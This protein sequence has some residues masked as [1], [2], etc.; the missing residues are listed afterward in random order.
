MPIVNDSL[1]SDY[2]AGAK[3]P[4]PPARSRGRSRG[5]ASVNLNAPPLE[6]ADIDAQGL[7]VGSGLIVA[8]ENVPAK[9][10]GAQRIRQTHASQ[11]PR[12][13]TGQA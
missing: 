13:S 2:I 9:T 12:Q 10:R 4:A 7:V 1:I 5:A 3:L 11:F 8:A 6:L